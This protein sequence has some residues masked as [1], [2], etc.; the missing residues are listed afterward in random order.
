MTNHEYDP[1][2]W[3]QEPGEKSAQA[4]LECRK[5]NDKMG[6]YKLGTEKLLVFGRDQHASHYVLANPS[7]S[8]THAA[9]I[10]DGLGGIFLV[11]LMSRHGTFLGANKQKK[12]LP[13]YEPTLL[14][15]GDVLTFGQSIRVYQLENVH[16]EGPSARMKKFRKWKLPSFKT[17][18]SSG[19]TS[20]DMSP[21]IEQSD[22]TVEETT[23]GSVKPKIKKFDREIQKLVSDICS[24]SNPTEL[25]FKAFCY[26]VQHQIKPEV[27]HQVVPLLFDKVRL[28]YRLKTSKIHRNA[29]QALL[30]LIQHKL[31]LDAI[32]C[33]V[34]IAKI[35]TISQS[36]KDSETRSMARQMLQLLAEIAVHPEKEITL[37]P[38]AEHH[39]HRRRNSS[40]SSRSSSH[41]SSPVSGKDKSKKADA[42]E[43]KVTYAPPSMASLAIT[44]NRAHIDSSDSLPDDSTK[45]RQVSP[46]IQ[47]ERR[48][49]TEG[50][51]LFKELTESPG[52]IQ[53]TLGVDSLGG[54]VVAH[55]DDPTGDRKWGPQ[56]Q[57]RKKKIKRKNRGRKNSITSVSPKKHQSAFQFITQ[58]PGPGSTPAS[59]FEFIQR[60]SPKASS[61]K[62]QFISLAPL[63]TFELWS[64]FEQIWAQAP[65]SLDWETTLTGP[66]VDDTLE[67][68]L[69]QH[70]VG[71]V[72]SGVIAGAQ[73][74]YFYAQH[75]SS[76]TVFMME[77]SLI[78]SG[79][80]SHLSC[81]FKW[82]IQD[83]L[84]DDGHVQ[85]IELVK[86][87]IEQ[88]FVEK[89]LLGNQPQL[90]LRPDPYV[91]PAEFENLWTIEA[92]VIGNVLEGALERFDTPERFESQ[93]REHLFIQCLASGPVG[94]GRFKFFFY[95]QAQVAPILFLMEITTHVHEGRYSIE[96]KHVS[97]AHVASFSGEEWNQMGVQLVRAIETYL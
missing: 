35:T 81:C 54:V 82:S 12:K 60:H 36:R 91:N 74:S 11:D 72:A 37:E 87:I 23:Q 64:D 2:E 92:S 22:D 34:V 68:V 30:Y 94:E 41:T 77:T 63:G 38:P 47:R 86:H 58:S 88:A 24:N 7:I 33:P 32:A 16:P 67:R 15:E 75:A 78:P 18:E 46:F 59:G 61:P 4:K 31:Y 9:I 70:H 76:S 20:T 57:K 89:Q 26:S 49:S 80:V 43:A 48:L 53:Q 97:D 14:R 79:S 45:E 69:E 21:T 96:L 3:A 93:M 65:D 62:K 5:G 6:T 13:P 17:F 40:M 90:E 44:V 19:S 25:K 73:K 39:H 50:L 8:R 28:K 95:A 52:G 83:L 29:L 66:G 71:C 55:P 1:P 85:F 56:D 84:Y 42:T 27:Q 51:K 10:H